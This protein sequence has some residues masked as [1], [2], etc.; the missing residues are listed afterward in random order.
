MG[1][2]RYLQDN[3]I[4]HKSRLHDGKVKCRAPPTVMNGYE[5]L[6]QLD[7]FEFPV[8]S[9]HPSIKG[10]RSSFSCSFL[11]TDAM[12]L[13]FVEDLDNPVGHRRWATIWISLIMV[14]VGR[15]YIEVSKSDLQFFVLDFNDQ[16][17]NRFVEHQMLSFFIEFRDDCH[18]HFK[19]YSDPK[20]ACANPPHLLVGRD[21][22][23]HYLYNHC[24]SRA[25]QIDDRTTQKV[26]VGDPSPRLARQ[27]V[28]VVPRRHVR[29]PQ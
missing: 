28:R 22:D 7:Q 19:K 17:L 10:T 14:D 20:E 15:E 4:W 24:M 6:E 3:H 23:W 16:A 26:F 18:R 11:K 29:S 9:K 2:R 8:M 1:H 27:P 12:F 25:F 5:I 21:E 13:E